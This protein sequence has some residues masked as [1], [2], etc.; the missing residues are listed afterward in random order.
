MVFHYL[1]GIGTGFNVWNE[2]LVQKYGNKFCPYVAEEES[3]V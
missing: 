2:I 3:T 1:I